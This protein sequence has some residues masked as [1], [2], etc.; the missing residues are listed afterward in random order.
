MGTPKRG[1]GGAKG[2]FA[3]KETDLMDWA[4]YYQMTVIEKNVT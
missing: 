3:N 4:G 1:L 2:A